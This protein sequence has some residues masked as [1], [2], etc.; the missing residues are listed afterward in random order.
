VKAQST[1]LSSLLLR[2]QLTEAIV[3]RVSFGDQH[4][5]VVERI[6]PSFIIRELALFCLEGSQ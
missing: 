1:N 5:T 3:K 4:H 2:I 6:P